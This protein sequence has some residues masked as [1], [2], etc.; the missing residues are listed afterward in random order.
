MKKIEFTYCGHFEYKGH[1]V[2]EVYAPM[3]R[4]Q[5]GAVVSNEDDTF[6]AF[7]DPNDSYEAQ[8][9]GIKHELDDHLEHRDFDNIKD[10][11]ANTLEMDAHHVQTQRLAEYAKELEIKKKEKEE[12]KRRQRMKRWW[13]EE[14]RYMRKRREEAESFYIMTHGYDSGLWG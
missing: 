9:E 14:Q 4:R 5:H 2:N 8:L 7:I 10:K 3:P 1:T 13:A 6:T 11:N 12:K